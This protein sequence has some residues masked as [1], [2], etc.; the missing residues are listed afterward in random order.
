MSLKQR[1]RNVGVALAR[2][3]GTT[4]VDARTGRR[5]G[6]ALLIPWR[7]RIH[8]IGLEAAVR[9]QF[10]PQSRVTYWKQQIGFT[11]HPPPDYPNVRKDNLT[12]PANDA[13]AAQD[14]SGDASQLERR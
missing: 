12:S 11:Q 5:L 7:G 9:P 3:V 6:K 13:E 1:I 8:V 14:S 2:A 10:L 4:I